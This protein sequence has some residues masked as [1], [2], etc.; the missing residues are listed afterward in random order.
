MEM[1][2]MATWGLAV[3]TSLSPLRGA[4]P[5]AADLEVGLLVDQSGEPLAHQ[6]VIVHKEDLFFSGCPR[7]VSFLGF[8][9]RSA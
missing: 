9:D 8:Q 4:A 6:W 1:S 2:T 3:A 5:L 7:L